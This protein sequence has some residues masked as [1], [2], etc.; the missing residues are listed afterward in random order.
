M[1]RRGPSMGGFGF[2]SRKPR[3]GR[4]GTKQEAGMK[5]EEKPTRLGSG[6]PKPE[7]GT[8]IAIPG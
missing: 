2:T 7:S 4:S 8:P 1:T 6:Q 3:S 5:Q